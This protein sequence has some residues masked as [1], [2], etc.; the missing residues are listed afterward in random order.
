MFRMACPPTIS[1]FVVPVVVRKAIKRHPVRTNA[2]V[3][4]EIVKYFPLIAHGDTATD[5][6]LIDI[7]VDVPASGEHCLP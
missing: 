3:F 4:K 1:W 7:P 5:V 2:H 6:L